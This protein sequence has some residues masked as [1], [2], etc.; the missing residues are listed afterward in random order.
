MR[1]FVNE[2]VK[3]R[4]WYRPLAPS[5]LDEHSGDWFEGLA[6][7][8][9]QS[10]YMSFTGDPPMSVVIYIP[11]VCCLLSVVKCHAMSVVTS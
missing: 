3:E 11:Y 6:N 8:A 7:N 4:E 2:K 9:N 10:P 5:V 1:R